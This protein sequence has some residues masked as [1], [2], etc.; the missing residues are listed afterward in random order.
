[1]SYFKECLD[2]CPFAKGTKKKI[3]RPVLQK[4]PNISSFESNNVFSGTLPRTEVDT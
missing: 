4:T 1:M 2:R 3:S